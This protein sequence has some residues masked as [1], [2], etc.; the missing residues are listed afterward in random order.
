[1]RR[2]V[3]VS[4]ALAVLLSTAPVRAFDVTVCHQTVP[5][6]EV[7]T[8]MNDLFCGNNGG[9]NVTV[10]GGSTL[11][12]NGHRIDGG[13]IGVLTNPGGLVRILGPGEITGA[14]ADSF[15]AAIAPSGKVFID[16][17][18]LHRNRRGIVAV[19]DASIRLSNVAITDNAEQG[20]TSSFAFGDSVVGPGTGKISG[21]GVTVT[22]NGGDGISVDGTL[23]LR[24][25]GINENGGA[26]I[27]TRGKR[28]FFQDVN[29]T[30]NGGGGIVS[31]SLKRSKLKNSSAKGNGAEGD[32]AAPVA[33]KLVSS[34]C[35]H[36]VDTDSG[37]TLG[38]C[39]GD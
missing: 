26:G 38:I 13:F 36:S 27:R 24:D 8:L 4:A 18:W 32:I 10:N 1:M 15:G 28:F 25:A 39:T 17:V 30:N 33:P 12:L 7:A 11:K 22:G 16:T 9:P 23:T 29:V 37:G 6:G 21:R 20:I 35:E 19:H 2:A 14:D 34:T 3:I 31:T 5:K